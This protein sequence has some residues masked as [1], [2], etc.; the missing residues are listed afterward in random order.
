MLL[1]GFDDRDPNDWDDEECK[2]AD[3]VNVP[4]AILRSSDSD[5]E[6]DLPSMTTNTSSTGAVLSVPAA[7]LCSSDGS[8]EEDDG[9]DSK[10]LDSADTGLS[11]E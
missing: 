7:T 1:G 8:E 10:E 11:G 5:D 3:D 9:E 6:Q 2:T 4:V